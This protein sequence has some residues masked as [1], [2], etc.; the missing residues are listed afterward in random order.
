M[1][2]LFIVYINCT[3]QHGII[4]KISQIAADYAKLKYQDFAVVIQP[5]FSKAKADLFPVEFL[6]NVCSFII[7]IQNYL[8]A[9]IFGM[10][11]LERSIISRVTPVHLT[12]YS[13][14]G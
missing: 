9:I 5:F 1:L 10:I 7:I 4:Y 14:H 3:I 8:L 2:I 11:R 6:S 12:S 13:W